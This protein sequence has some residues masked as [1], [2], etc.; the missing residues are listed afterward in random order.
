MTFV[1]PTLTPVIAFK[2]PPVILPVATI[3][4][5][6]SKLPPVMLPTAITCPDALTLLP[7]MFPVT[8]TVCVLANNTTV[9][10]AFLRNK[11]PSA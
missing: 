7:E 3:N 4:P 6:V 11:L 10:A 1:V 5:V 8:L 2:L 9:L